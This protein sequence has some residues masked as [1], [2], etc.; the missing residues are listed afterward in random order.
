MDIATSVKQ[1]SDIV[2]EAA[3]RHTF[4]K[5]AQ[6]ELEKCMRSMERLKNDLGPFEKRFNK[7]SREAWGEYQKGNMGDDGDIMEWMMLFENYRSLQNQCE[8]INAV[9]FK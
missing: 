4:K 2:G 3:V 9:E 1:M 6:I 5:L 8:R 7:S